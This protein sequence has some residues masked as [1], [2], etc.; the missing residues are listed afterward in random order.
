MPAVIIEYKDI[1]QEV[2]ECTAHYDTNPYIQANEDSF[3]FTVH[4]KAKDKNFLVKVEGVRNLT[5]RN[6]TDLHVQVHFQADYC[7]ILHNSQMFCVE[8]NKKLAR[9]LFNLISAEYQHVLNLVTMSK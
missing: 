1:L 9:F 3:T 7:K 6:R 2:K 8:K 4:N 5:Y